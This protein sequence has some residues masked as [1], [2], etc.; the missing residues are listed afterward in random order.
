M[1]D[2]RRVLIVEDDETIRQ[3]LA[4][5]MREDG[6]DVR[7]AAC[8]ECALEILG[9]WSPQVIL[10]DVMMPGMGGATFRAM[11]QEQ[12]L[13]N[14]VPLIVVSASRTAVKEAESLGATGVVM[15]PFDL[16]YLLD[17]VEHTLEIQ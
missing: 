14:G 13:A 5:A 9:S 12:G 6:Y 7:E 16:P 2:A 10:L 17:L 1:V 4:D 15:K 8:G 11:Q 3:V